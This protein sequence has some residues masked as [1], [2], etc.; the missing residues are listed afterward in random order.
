MIYTYYA[1]EDMHGR[2]ICEGTHIKTMDSFEEA[3]EYAAYHKNKIKYVV[4]FQLNISSE[5]YEVC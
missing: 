2:L 3:S 1:F 5:K 4:C